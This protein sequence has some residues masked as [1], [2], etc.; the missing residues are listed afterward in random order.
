MPCTVVH[1]IGL[2]IVVII[3]ID[4]EYNII[5]IIKAYNENYLIVNISTDTTIDVQYLTLVIHDIVQWHCRLSGYLLVQ[6]YTVSSLI[7][8]LP[9]SAMESGAGDFN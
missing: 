7:D 8:T 4:T 1:D 2:V 3:N 5:V 6:S 9:Y